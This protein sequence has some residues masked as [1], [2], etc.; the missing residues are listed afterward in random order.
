[1]RA[2]AKIAWRRPRKQWQRVATAFSQLFCAGESQRRLVIGLGLVGGSVYPA[3]VATRRQLEAT[4]QAAE[5]QVYQIAD[6]QTRA[7]NGWR[8]S[9]KRENVFAPQKMRTRSFV[10]AMAR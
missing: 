2:R 4:V 5:G 7:G 8:R 3:L 10:S 9:C 1:M 6:T